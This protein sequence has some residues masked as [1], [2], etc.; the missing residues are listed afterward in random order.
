MRATSPTG[1]LLFLRRG[2]LFAVPFDVERARDSRPRRR[3]VLPTVAQALTG[4]HA[5][6]ETGAGQFAFAAT[7]MLAWVRAE[8]VQYPAGP[9]VT[10]DR[11]GNVAALPE[12]A[13]PYSGPVRVSPD[14]RQL[15]ALVQT[16]TEMGLWIYD[17][18]STTLTP[19]NQDSVIG[20]GIWWPPDGRRLV[21]GQFKGGQWTLSVQP[22]DGSAPARLLLPGQAR[23][24]APVSFTPD[25]R[26]LLGVRDG[27]IVV[28]TIENGQARV[29][30]GPA[31]PEIE[32]APEVSPDG[33]WLAFTSN[34]SGR[35][36]VYVRPYPG[37]GAVEQVS[38]DG[39]VS[40]AFKP[41]GGELCFLSPNGPVFIER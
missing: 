8:V 26:Q 23:P 5:A 20:R 25:G 27:D 35:D 17:M 31:T 39:G 18:D 21:F 16:L 9:L 13:K 3:P 29:E 4:G 34:K 41:A 32:G 10:V 14:G 2:T 22:A 40:P 15:A 1:H 12:S 28:V 7:G 11:K 33:H 19:L 37:P 24:V 30:P 6:D 38:V 36:E